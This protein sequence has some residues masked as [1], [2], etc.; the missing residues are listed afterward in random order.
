MM[1]QMMNQMLSLIFAVAIAPLALGETMPSEN[2]VEYAAIKAY[3]SEAGDVQAPYGMDYTADSEFVGVEDSTQSYPCKLEAEKH[4]MRTF[5]SQVGIFDK[6]NMR[7]FSKFYRITGNSTYW[8]ETYV[9][10]GAGPGQE[11]I[12]ASMV[13][14]ETIDQQCQVLDDSPIDLNRDWY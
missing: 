9:F 8:W 13:R 1:N 2:N 5:Q 14:L 4:A 3:Q 6:K 10:K 12:F 11:T 7:L